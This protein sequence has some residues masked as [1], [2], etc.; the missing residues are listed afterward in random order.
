MQI[1]WLTV[2]AQIVNFLV[3]VW[4]LQRFLYRPITTAMRRREDR[5]EARL[6]EAREAR[7]TAEAEER[8]LKEKEADLDARADA[9]IADAREEAGELR[10]RLE[11]ELREEMEE[12][13]AAW[14]HHLAEER[15]ALVASLRRQAGRKVLRIAERVLADYADSDVAERVVGTFTDR[16][17]ALDAKTRDALA[18]AAGDTEAT[19]LVET[20]SALGTDARRKVTR[21]IQEALSADIDVDYREDPELVMG[22]R[23]SIGDYAAEWSAARYLRRLET[24]L[25]EMIDAGTGAS[26]RGGDVGDDGTQDE[27]AE[28]DAGEDDGAERDGAESDA[29]E[30]D[31]A[32]DD[33]AEDDGA[34]N[35]GADTPRRTDR[36]PGSE[37]R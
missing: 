12:K 35:G 9:I 19:A 33:R 37:A 6:A 29:G 31:R 10:K 22:L 11:R 4:L 20:G 1:D 34:E 14:H 16:L 15:D 30:R 28:S 24:E 7:E 13:R 18:A 27:G 32:E 5:I 2:A 25:G 26:D 8:R 36:A 23:L 3:L 17:A 21:A